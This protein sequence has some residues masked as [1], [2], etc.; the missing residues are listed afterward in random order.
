[1]KAPLPLFPTT[2]VG[3]MP[4]PQYVKDLLHA[5]SRT[6]RHDDT[7]QRRMDDAVRFVIGMQEQAGIDIISDGEWRRETYVDVVAEIMDGF[8]WVRRD[9]F[10]YHQVVTSKLTPRR[11]GVVAEE[12]RF[13][14]ENTSRHVKVCLPSPYLIGERMWEPQ[15]SATAYP[16]R[17]EFCEALVPVLRAELLAIR[18]VGVDVIQLDE[19]HLCVLVD[20]EVRA[21]FADPE[22][23]MRRAVD[24]IN[25]IVEGVEGVT[26]AVHLCRRNWGRRGWGAAG[27][28]EAIL[29]HLKRLK[30]DQL[31]MEFSIPVAGDVAVLRDL[32]E[33]VKVGLGCV[34][35][36]FPE[37]DPPER[38]VE[39]VEKA[40][41]HVAADRISLNPDCGFAPGKDHE[42]PL[43]EA[44]AKLENLALAGQALRQRHAPGAG[45]ESARLIDGQ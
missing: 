42:I 31:L 4:R 30:V 9:V 19:P 39:R 32:P 43:E 34:D 1:M 17:A 44:Y 41:G 40:L 45:G 11:P 33:N 37:V 3:S 36:R 6:G 18:E 2:V 15:H 12:A 14:K 23:E 10:A 24:M 21:R 27:G 22:G 25:R 29:A 5:G 13:L 28:Y 35:V 26:L 20:P 7:W 8:E 38:I 16:T